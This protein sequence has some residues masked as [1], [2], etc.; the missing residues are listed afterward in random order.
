MNRRVEE[1]I[2]GQ[3]ENIFFA[4]VNF[5]YLSTLFFL[6]RGWTL[7]TFKIFK[8]T[9]Q[10]PAL[11]RVRAHSQQKCLG[12]C[13]VLANSPVSSPVSRQAF[14][15]LWPSCLLGVQ[16][17]DASPEQQAPKK[18]SCESVRVLPVL[19]GKSPSL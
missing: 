14:A 10:L 2:G 5:L 3:K 11:V 12:P 8:R 15:V 6:Y 17:E 18:P 7:A 4:S 16:L 1:D 19:R 9:H 13:R